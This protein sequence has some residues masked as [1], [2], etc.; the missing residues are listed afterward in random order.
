MKFRNQFNHVFYD[1]YNVIFLGP[2]PPCPQM[3][4]VTCY[5][6]KSTPAV[7]RCSASNWSCSKT[8]STLLACGTHTCPDVCHPGP[9]P[10][11]SKT[12]TQS[13][14]CGKMAEPRPCSTPVWKCGNKC[15]KKLKC[16]H[17]VC[18][19]VCHE[20]G[21]FIFFTHVLRRK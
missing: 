4:T 5:C 11:C 14:S 20:Q 6:A 9:C 13:C 15:G 2:C 3:V 17:H 18:D 12:S 21:N 10:P 19:Y 8:C 1:W 7:K 16:G